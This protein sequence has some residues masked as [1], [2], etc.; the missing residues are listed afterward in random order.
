MKNMCGK[1]ENLGVKNAK[2]DLIIDVFQ[3]GEKS[4]SERGTDK[5]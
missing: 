4:F 2:G 1:E 3:E 5:L